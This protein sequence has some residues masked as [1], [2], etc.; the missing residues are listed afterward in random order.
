[1]NKKIIVVYNPESGRHNDKKFVKDVR[2]FLEKRNFEVCFMATKAKGDASRII[3]TLDSEGVN[4]VLVCGGDGT[5]NE[6]ISGNVARSERLELAYLPF[7]TTNDVGHMYG[8]TK[9]Y[10]KDLKILVDGIIK[11]IDICYVNKKPFVYVCC[12]GN[13]VNVSYETPRRLKKKYGKF[14]YI[15]YGLKQIKK[16]LRSYELSYKVNGE[17]HRGKYSFIFITNSSRIAGVKGI[18]NDVKLDDKKFEVAFCNIEKKQD[19]VKVLYE[20]STMD[21]E[22]I[23]EIE[24]YK[25]DRIEIVFDEVPD[26]SWCIDGEEYKEETKK[27]V[28]TLDNDTRMLMPRKN[29]KKLFK[30]KKEC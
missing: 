1:M 14:A 11:N 30:N 12:L 26:F 5:L 22:D 13:F 8:L 18:Y 10:M 29:I 20:I 2:S 7:G 25:T 28:F 23:P 17:I 16:S 27:F 24:Y 4:L 6:A 3:R 21:I 15:I 9:N 19:V